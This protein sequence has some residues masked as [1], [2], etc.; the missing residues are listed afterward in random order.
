MSDLLAIGA[1]GVRAYQTALTTVS[2]NIANAGTAGFS[3]RTTTLGEISAINARA[4]ASASGGSG[5]TVTGTRRAGDELRQAAV[6]SAGS[7]IGR[8]QSGITWLSEI[9]GALND[10]TLPANLTAFF[11]AAKSVAADPTASAPRAAFI[12]AGTSVANSFNLTGKALDAANASLDTTAQNAVTQLNGL[13]TTLGQVNNGLGAAQANTSAN[14]QLL[15]QRDQLLE[16]VSAIT[17]A[18]VTTDDRGRVT[19]RLGDASGPV[20]LTGDIPAYVSYARNGSGAVAFAVSRNGSVD[21]LTPTGGALAG[22]I[23]GA[24]RIAAARTEINQ[25][26]SDFTSQIN[27]FQA[28]G[29]DLNGNPGA[30]FFTVGATPTDISV[31]I[32]DP[33]TVAAAAVGGGTRDNSNIN[34]LET[35]RSQSGFENNLTTIISANASA[36]SARRQVADAQNSIFDGAVAARDSVT[37]VNL[38]A[39]AVDLVR[40]QQAY[41]ASGRVIQVAQDTFQTILNIR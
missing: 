32:T 30:A 1:T 20:A 6:R 8:T 16:Q 27:N 31:A 4:S 41:Q 24:Q 29:R 38:D 5:V 23:D 3:R 33:S 35:L 15:D 13:L 34:T 2:D 37:G 7:D 19:L 26:A 17:N 21:S 40:Y 22:V 18:T 10:N 9:E 12:E 28:Q 25:L 11:N 36:L 39:E 14:A